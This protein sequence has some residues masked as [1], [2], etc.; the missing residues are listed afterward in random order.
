MAS[1]SGD[2]WAGRKVRDVMLRDPKTV[3][4]NASVGVVRQLFENPRVQMAL[5]VDGDD[6]FRGAV[7]RDDLPEDAI[8]DRLALLFAGPTT[9]V[10]P[11]MDAGEAFDEIASDP[12][13]RLVVLD[14]DGEKL[15]GLLC[16]NGARD[17]FCGSPKAS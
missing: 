7:T 6:V 10:D 16:L 13:R 17:G 12:S 3:D 8:S 11:D 14:G 9:P 1:E 5:L 4:A 2:R 15:V